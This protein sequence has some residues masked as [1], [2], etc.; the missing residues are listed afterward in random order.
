[1]SK[2]GVSSLLVHTC[3]VKYSLA[4]D[5]QS[6]SPLNSQPYSRMVNIIAHTKARFW[7]SSHRLPTIIYSSGHDNSA[8]DHSCFGIVFAYYKYLKINFNVSSLCEAILTFN[9]QKERCGC[10]KT[11]TKKVISV[12]K[13]RLAKSGNVITV[14]CKIIAPLV[15]K[16]YCWDV[17]H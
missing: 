5:R 17:G 11:Q 16:Y 2:T 6:K 14:Q 13:N 12:V 3:T 15:I 9:K 4:P 1:M 8:T 10:R 7:T